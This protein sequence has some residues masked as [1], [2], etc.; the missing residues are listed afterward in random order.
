MALLIAI[1]SGVLFQNIKWDRAAYSG[2]T[3]FKTSAS[4]K[5]RGLFDYTEP[6]SDNPDLAYRVNSVP[7]LNNGIINPRQNPPVWVRILAT[8]Q[9]GIMLGFFFAIMVIALFFIFYRNSRNCSEG[10]DDSFS[11][12]S[13]FRLV[14]YDNLA[15]NE[16]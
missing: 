3:K 11:S 2:L 12:V 6:L 4:E 1:L 8:K 5:I 9:V 13:V 15:W 14:F 7:A 16:I 10:D